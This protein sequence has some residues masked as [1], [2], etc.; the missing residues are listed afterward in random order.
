LIPSPG[1]AVSGDLASSFFLSTGWQASMTAPAET[2]PAINVL[3]D[4]LLSMIWLL[5][6]IPWYG[7]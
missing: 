7:C 3:M 6:F 5:F 1:T 2:A 4:L